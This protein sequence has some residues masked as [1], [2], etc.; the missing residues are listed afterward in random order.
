MAFCAIDRERNYK[1]NAARV[2][3]YFMS[4]DKG[5]LK[6]AYENESRQM[7]TQPYD[8]VAIHPAA[9]APVQRVYCWIYTDAMTNSVQVEMITPGA[10]TVAATAT[11]NWVVPKEITYGGLEGTVFYGTYDPKTAG[12]V[13]CD[14]FFYRGKHVTYATWGEKLQI[15]RELFAVW[16]LPVAHF[17]LP[18]MMTWDEFV[19]KGDHRGAD[20][21]VTCA[22]V[23]QFFKAHSKKASVIW[24]CNG[25]RRAQAVPVPVRTHPAMK[26]AAQQHQPRYRTLWTKADQRNDIYHLYTSPETTETDKVGLALVPNFPA[27]IKMN[28]IFRN[29]RANRSLDAL[30]ESDDEAEFENTDPNKYLLDPDLC[31]A[32]DYEWNTRFRKYQPVFAAKVPVCNV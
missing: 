22:T 24:H 18:C 2:R 29:I 16:K 21:A 15:Y 28:A 20:G 27:S 19:A 11:M 32:I 9:P 7:P 17:R 30:E 6:L 26:P 10:K 4:A 1:I 12:F 13:I 14:V 31:V 8:W 25:G 5:P 23:M 3:S